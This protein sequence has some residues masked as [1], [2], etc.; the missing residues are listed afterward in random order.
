[1]TNIERQI[2]QIIATDRIDKPISSMSGKLKRAK[3][4]LAQAVELSGGSFEGSRAYAR[5]EESDVMKARGMRN[6]ID[7]FSSEHP[8][9]GAILNGYIEEER[10]RTETHLY[11]GMQEGSRLTSNDY[12]GVMTNLG[13]SEGV[14]EGLYPE[15]MNISYKLA[16]K[17]DEGERSILIGN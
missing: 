12:M 2:L 1:M 4:K 11:F 9:Y 15:L 6:G 14:A 10:A 17:R 13:L 5:V 16:R 3:P 8:R 7:A